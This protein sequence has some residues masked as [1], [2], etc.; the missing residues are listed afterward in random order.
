MQRSCWVGSRY[1]SVEGTKAMNLCCPPP[2]YSFWPQEGLFLRSQDSCWLIPT[3][4]RSLSQGGEIA[5]FHQHRSGN[6][7]S[8]SPTQP[9]PRFK[10]NNTHSSVE[11]EYGKD[12][13]SLHPQIAGSCSLFWLHSLACSCQLKKNGVV[14]YRD[15]PDWNLLRCASKEPQ[16]CEHEHASG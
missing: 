8:F 12:S 4:I 7:F 14:I 3:Q 2:S 10:K 6:N 9:S 16:H 11:G 5:L 15:Q 13:Q 1:Q